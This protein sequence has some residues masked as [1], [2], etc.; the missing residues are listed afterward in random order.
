MR[1]CTLWHKHSETSDQLE[2]PAQSDQ[3]PRYLTVYLE[4]IIFCARK[5]WSHERKKNEPFFF[6]KGILVIV[7]K[8]ILFVM[9]TGI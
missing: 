5:Q 7:W 9:V 1:K 3:G 8:L 4:S 2:H 6:S